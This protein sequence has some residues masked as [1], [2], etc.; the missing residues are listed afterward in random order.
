[1]VDI[2]V[3]ATA[4]FGLG[5]MVLALCIKFVYTGWLIIKRIKQ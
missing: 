2:F 4:F 1:M 5:L 3:N